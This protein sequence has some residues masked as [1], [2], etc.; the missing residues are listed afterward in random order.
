MD[1]LQS[2]NRRLMAKL[3]VIAVG[4]F[5]FGFA[6]VPFY[7][8]ICEATGINNL[9]RPDKVENTQVVASRTVTVELDANL[10][11]DLPWRFAPE[12]R[13]LQVH[14][15]QMVQVVYDIENN[16]PRPIVAQAIPSYGP[17]RAGEYFNK[18]ECFCFSKQQFAAGEKRRM[19]VVFVIDPSLPEDIHTITL[20]YSFFEVAGTAQPAA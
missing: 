19:P 13:K 1:T 16:G 9:L 10:R 4:M 6:L 7:D 18:L 20:S 8:Q 17:K 14:P 15:G 12:Q 3:I 2:D 5:G 11:A